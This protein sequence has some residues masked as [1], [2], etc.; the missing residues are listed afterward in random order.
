MPAA[1]VGDHIGIAERGVGGQGNHM[2]V[3]GPGAERGRSMMGRGEGMGGGEV[4]MRRWSVR[5]ARG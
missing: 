5:G 2:E 3:V 1:A 4:E